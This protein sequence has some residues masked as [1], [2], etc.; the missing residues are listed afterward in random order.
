MRDLL[1]AAR[2]AAKMQHP[3]ASKDLLAQFQKIVLPR[4]AVVAGY[5]AMGDEIS[6][7][8][9]LEFL[10]AQ[11]F[12]LC[13]PL[14]T[15]DNTPLEFHVWHPSHPTAKGKFNI[16]EPVL[17]ELVVPDVLL[18]PL[19][20]FDRRGNRIGYGKGFYDRTLAALRT[21]HKIIAIGLAYA[22]QEMPEIMATAHDQPLNIIVTPAE[23]IYCVAQP[24]EKI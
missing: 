15:S 21:Q 22:E 19:L 9:I 4:G 14:V 3:N 16:H 1:K 2:A 10:A 6:P 11:K 18:V 8:P 12:S 7:A 23:T 20:G 5:A 17:R 13:L 24:P